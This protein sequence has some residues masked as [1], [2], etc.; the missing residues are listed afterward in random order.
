[1]FSAVDG[2]V[3]VSAPRMKVELT[4]RKDEIAGRIVIPGGT[5]GLEC[6]TM[7]VEQFASDHEADEKSVLEDIWATYLKGKTK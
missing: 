1:M 3:Q 4:Q 2:G 7:I 5:F 6:I